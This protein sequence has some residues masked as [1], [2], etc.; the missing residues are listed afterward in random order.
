MGRV[1]IVCEPMRQGATYID[2]TPAVKHGELHVL[3]PYT[4]SMLAPVPT[5]RMLR[6]KLKDF[7]DDDYLIA[8]GDPVLIGAACMVAGEFNNGKIKF[9]KWDRIQEAYYAIQVDT[10]GKAT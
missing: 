9:L 2:F 7:S 3:L 4:Q 6:E 10:S 1:F 8:T 5:V